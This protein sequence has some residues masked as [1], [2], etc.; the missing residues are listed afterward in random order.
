MVYKHNKPWKWKVEWLRS[1]I[2]NEQCSLR[3]TNAKGKCSIE[4][5]LSKNEEKTCTLLMKHQIIIATNFN[6]FLKHKTYF[7][8]IRK[9]GIT[10]EQLNQQL[11]KNQFLHEFKKMTISY[12]VKLAA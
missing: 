5:Y 9:T 12:K 2:N 10:D 8:F 6:I 7:T 4:T 3:K 11:T 1:H